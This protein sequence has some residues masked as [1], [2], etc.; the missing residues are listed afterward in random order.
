MKTNRIKD[1]ETLELELAYGQEGAREKA[2]GDLIELYWSRFIRISCRVAYQW[3]LLDPL[4]DAQDAIQE[5][6]LS[7]LERIET[8]DPS[9]GKSNEVFRRWFTSIIIQK[10][11]AIRDRQ[12]FIVLDELGLERVIRVLGREPLG[13]ERQALGKAKFKEL[14][15]FVNTPKKSR[16]LEAR[17]M[18]NVDKMSWE[19]IAR[20]LSWTGSKEGLR[21][22]ASRLARQLKD[23]LETQET[24]QEA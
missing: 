9:K 15:R 20:A 5:A 6:T 14:M 11:K 16:L 21:A 13:P 22:S 24:A 8:F 17:L 2:L 4:A 19:N 18:R 23:K 1:K 10:L 12:V 3:D 7:A